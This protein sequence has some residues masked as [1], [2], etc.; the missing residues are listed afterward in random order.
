MKSL[1]RCI[2]LSILLLTACNGNKVVEL[3][4]NKEKVHL[5]F[6]TPKIETEPIFEELIHEFEKQH[7]TIDISQEVIPEGMRVLKTRIARGDI[8]DIFITYPIE[9]DYLIR[10]DKGYLLD[11]THED[12][13]QN[14]EPSI[15]NRYLVNGKMYGAAL[16]QNAVGV[17]YN[18]DHFQELNL[19]IPQ[20]WDEFIEVMEKL[21]AAGKTPLLM[22]N[23]DANRSSIFNLN[24]VAN[25]I[26]TH[27]W[28]KETFSI[29]KNKEWREISEKTITA[30][31]YVQL[32]SFQDDFFEVNRKF[33]NGQGSMYVM[34][35]WA[36]TEIEK[37]NPNLHY[38][39]FPF[40]ATNQPKQNKVLG[41]VD[42]GLAISSNT[43]HPKEA[44]QFLAFLTNKE[45]AQRLS[46][47]EGSISTV[48]GVNI[49]TPQLELLNEKIHEGKTVNWPNH[50]WAGGTAAESD[51]RKY[52]LQFYYDKNIDTFL[53]NLED[54]FNYYKDLK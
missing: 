40:P 45:I 41:G 21:K 52:T 49:N 36:L 30:L 26:N 8:P 28:E 18:I 46:D 33:A 10:A 25:D 9:Q 19:S 43:K 53:N 42:I 31:S 22:P 44:K 13:I 48:K 11:L 12:F 14:I 39:I 51:F 54:M 7:P 23:K 47:Y 24:F 5:E 6:F 4:T 34:G 38:G 37:H 32:N 20:T 3:T 1:F 16:T 29:S 17:L 35:T 15:Q 50:Y 27:Y 2:C